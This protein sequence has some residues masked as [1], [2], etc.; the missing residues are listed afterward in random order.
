MIEYRYTKWLYLVYLLFLPTSLFLFG[1][2]LLVL[3]SVISEKWVAFAFVIVVWFWFNLYLLLKLVKS[4]IIISSDALIVMT[5]F[6]TFDIPLSRIVAYKSYSIEDHHVV[7]WGTLRQLFP[8][9]GS[10]Q[11]F[12]IYYKDFKGKKKFLREDI[13]NFVNSKE[14]LK[15]LDNYLKK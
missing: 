10:Q 8:M 15:N 2:S 1:L 7:W 11:W 5:A 6:R 13:T 4:K 14:L 12:E 9:N 3:L